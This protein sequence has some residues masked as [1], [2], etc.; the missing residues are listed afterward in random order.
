VLGGLFSAVLK[1]KI[2]HTRVG[3]YVYMRVLMGQCDFQVQVAS[4]KQA[5]F[6]VQRQSKKRN[7]R[8]WGS[9]FLQF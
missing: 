6:K 8:G 9:W 1:K 7:A 4:S 2:T 5:Q 3:V